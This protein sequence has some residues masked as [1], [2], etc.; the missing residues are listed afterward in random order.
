M[1][2]SPHLLLITDVFRLL[3]VGHTDEFSVQCRTL[4]NLRQL[5]V[6]HD[7][8]GKNPAWHPQVSYGWTHSSSPVFLQHPDYLPLCRYRPDCLSLCLQLISVTDTSTHVTWWF[9]AN[10]WFDRTQGDCLIERILMPLSAP[11]PQPRKTAAYQ[12]VVVTSDITGAGTDARVYMV[13]YGQ[14]GTDSGRLSLDKPGVNL[15]ERAQRDVFEVRSISIGR[16]LKKHWDLSYVLVAL[17]SP[18]PSSLLTL[19]DLIMLR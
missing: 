13:M 1:F 10:M 5:L 15:F 19:P 4:G 17:L 7:N 6:G 16:E 9:D 14:D 18:P 3:S 8:S 12:V 11:P 2:S